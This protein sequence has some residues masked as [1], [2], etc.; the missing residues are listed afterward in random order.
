LKAK[1]QLTAIHRSQPSFTVRHIAKIGLIRPKVFDFGSGTGADVNFLRSLNYSAKSW[2]PF[3]NRKTPPL[4][5]EPHQFKTIF[6]TYVL[7]VIPKRERDK[8]LKQIGKLLHKQGIAFIT[9]R[10]SKDI[11]DKAK[12]NDWHK[13][14]DGWIT[15]RGTFQKGFE[16][17]ELKSL[18]RRCGFQYA[19]TLYTNP[20]IVIAFEDKNQ[21]PATNLK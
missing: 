20:L 8:V 16:P 4:S 14:D 3:F 6:C 11:L 9:V 1:S 15:K 17:H 10:T 13:K 5:F 12:S 21:N 7:N 19:L 18:V 2:D